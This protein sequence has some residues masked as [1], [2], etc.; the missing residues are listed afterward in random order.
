MTPDTDSVRRWAEDILHQLGAFPAHTLGI[1]EVADTEAT[2]YTA[3]AN[4]PGPE[5]P[6]GDAAFASSL[7]P[8]P[9]GGGVPAWTMDGQPGVF[10]TLSHE[11]GSSVGVHLHRTMSAS[12]AVTLL[13]D[14]LQ[15]AVLENTEGTPVPACPGHPHPPT[16]EEVSGVPSWTCPRGGRTWPILSPTAR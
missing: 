3:N 1:T 2:G 5:L 13:A 8:R 10:V 11:D 6:A 4:G 15:E 16:A 7:E 14:V 9:D 12:E